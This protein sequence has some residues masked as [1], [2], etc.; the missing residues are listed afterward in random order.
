[1]KVLERDVKTLEEILH[2][3][4][5]ITEIDALSVALQEERAKH[6]ELLAAQT[7]L[8]PL[9]PAMLEKLSGTKLT[10]SVKPEKATRKK[11]GSS[12]ADTAGAETGQAG[13]EHT[14]ETAAEPTA[15]TT[16]P[17]DEAPTEEPAA[18]SEEQVA[19]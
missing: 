16:N 10:T 1:M 19:A 15:E 4:A 14:S 7:A 11:R 9:L 3:H 2:T 13:D 18:T 5:R 17:H 8:N 6:V 12:E